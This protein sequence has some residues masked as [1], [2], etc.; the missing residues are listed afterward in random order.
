MELNKRKLYIDGFN[1]RQSFEEIF[2]ICITYGKFARLIRPDRKPY[3]FLIY[4]TVEEAAAAKQKFNNSMVQCD[5]AR[6]NGNRVSSPDTDNSNSSKNTKSMSNGSD[7]SG[8]AYSSFN[9]GEHIFIT[10]ID[11]AHVYAIPAK[12]RNEY[13]CFMGLV[14][15]I[16]HKANGLKYP[17]QQ[18]S[19]ALAIHD[20]Y[21][22][23]VVVTDMVKMSDEF[24]RVYCCDVGEHKEVAVEQLKELD[25]SYFHIKRW[26]QRFQLKNVAGDDRIELDAA[27]YLASYI[28]TEVRV[29]AL[30]NNGRS[31]WQIEVIDPVTSHSINDIANL[32]NANLTVD[33]LILQ[34]PT[35]G[36]DRQ[37]YVV[38]MTLLK[39][40]DN[41]ITFVQRKDKL[42]FESQQIQIDEWGNEADP[43]PRYAGEVDKLGVVKIAD[44]WYRCMFLSSVRVENKTLV[45]LIDYCRSEW[46]NSSDIRNIARNI[47]FLPI[48]SFAGQ[49]VGYA[50]EVSPLEVTEIDNSVKQSELITVKDLQAPAN[51]DVIYNVTIY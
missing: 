42:T 38:D 49:I 46:V 36:C 35:L 40:G 25:K 39:N 6:A 18:H 16:G 37:L 50:D 41:L 47:A 7:H 13:A 21:Y 19:W 4:E 34:L 48:V 28:G 3:V 32:L 11:G 12:K 29:A 8:D 23:R 5:Y 10:H 26:A 45:Y 31:T 15:E 9:V 24:A 20:G 30:Y 2:D 1:E 44:K 27:K 43:F 22:A 51:D 33:S 14:A 17:I